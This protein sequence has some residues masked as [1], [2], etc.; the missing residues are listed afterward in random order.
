MKPCRR[1]RHLVM[2]TGLALVC[3]TLFA[4]QRVAAQDWPTRPITV[5]VPLGAG[6]ASDI[7]ARAVTEQLGRQLGQTIVV[8]NRPGAGG[9]TGA[10]AVGEITPDGFTI[11]VY[12]ASGLA[13]ALHYNLAYRTF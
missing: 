4:A 12:G 3:L 11:V 13:H 10:N 1:I 5:V 8:E 2:N 6:S 9:V 7:I